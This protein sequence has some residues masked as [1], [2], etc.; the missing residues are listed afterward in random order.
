MIRVLIQIE[1]KNCGEILERSLRPE[2]KN[3]VKCYSEKD[4][5]IC[6]AVGKNIM[7]VLR[8]I[9]DILMCISASYNICQEQ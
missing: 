4:K 9:D 2:N 7:S 8:S 1:I 6:E 5:I 3:Y